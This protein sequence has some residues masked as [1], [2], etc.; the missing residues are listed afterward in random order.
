[1][2]TRRYMVAVVVV[3]VAMG[4]FVAVRAVWQ[5]FVSLE[6]LLHYSG[7]EVTDRLEEQIGNEVEAM[8]QSLEM[9]EEERRAMGELRRTAALWHRQREYHA[10]MVYKYRYVARFPWLPVEPDP[11]EPQ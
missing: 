3:A 4:G 1:M 8:P 5:Y 10:A 6:R 2:T 11:P 7:M 9:T